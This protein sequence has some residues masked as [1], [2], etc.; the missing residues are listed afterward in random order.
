MIKVSKNE[1]GF[2]VVE[3]VIIIFILV[4]IG[5]AGWFVYREHHKTT[6]SS[7][8]VTNTWTGK[9]GNYNWNEKANWSLGEPVNGQNLEIDLADVKQPTDQYGATSFSFQDNIPNLSINKLIIDGKVMGVIFDIKGDPLTIADG[10]EDT[11][12]QTNDQNAIPQVRLD[13]SIFLSGN[14]TI[15]TTGKNDLTFLSNLGNKDG[16]NIGNHTVE[17]KVVGSSDISFMSPVSGT[18]EIYLPNNAISP[19]G[20]LLFYNYSPDFNGEVSIGKGNYVGISNADSQTG[21]YGPVSAFGTSL[22]NIQNGGAL[23]VFDAGTDSFTLNNPID[24]SGQG[25][26][27]SNGSS[28]GAISACL[29]NAEQGCG[30]SEQLTFSG[31]VKLLGN[32]QIGTYVPSSEGSNNTHVDYT[33]NNLDKNGY[34]LT[35][36]TDYPYY[37]EF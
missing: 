30:A 6:T 3:F 35:V 14:Q 33:F 16:L 25:I 23:N 32:T 37:A 34:S 22:I 11:I 4:L 2:S 28:T 24:I 31:T 19:A 12:A 8:A 26:A 10:V 18:G 15:L 29:T 36:V 9:S 5:A 21:G 13:N 7:E 17:F 20:E 27:N 1:K